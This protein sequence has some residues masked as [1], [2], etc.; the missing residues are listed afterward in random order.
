VPPRVAAAPFEVE[1][2]VEPTFSPREFGQQEAR[3]LG[4]ELT[5]SYAPDPS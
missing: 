5:F 3:R 2:T 4:A 1:I